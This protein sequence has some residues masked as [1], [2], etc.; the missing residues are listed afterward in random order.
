MRIAFSGTHYSGKSTLVAAFAAE[1][2]EWDV[3]DEPYWMLTELG[4]HFSNPPTLDDF[5]EQ[6][7]FSIRLIKESSNHAL[8]DRSPID[9]LAY[10]L[11][12]AEE[13]GEE[14]DGDKWESRA[15]EAMA[16]LD[17][18]VFLP[19]EDPDLIP[20]PLSEDTDLRRRVDEKLRELIAEDLK[21]QIVEVKGTVEERVKKIKAH[22]KINWSVR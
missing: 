8:F 15:A 3:Y 17:C 13:N 2:P 9:F 11:V 1:V 5:E 19:L 6:L 16:L 22:L 14:F 12:I 21:T 7:E 10:A 4:R 20:L 18:V